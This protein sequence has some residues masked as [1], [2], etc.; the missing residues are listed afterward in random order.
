MPWAVIS[1]LGWCISTLA[2]C[3]C[4]SAPLVFLNRSFDFNYIESVAVFP[5]ENLSQSQGA[6]Q[7]ATLMFVTEMLSLGSFDVV[8]MGE[9]SKAL[10]ELNQAR[11]GG[12][13]TPGTL[14]VQQIIQLGKRLKVQG[15]IFGTVG[16][17]VVLRSGGYSAPTITMDLRMVETETGTTVWAASHTESGS[18]WLSTLF[19]VSSKSTS[20]TMRECIHNI[21]KTLIK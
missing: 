7:Q 4:G 13:P 21:L 10:T 1:V 8:E 20:E 9:T 6:G 18:N 19:G 12:A 16:E 15:L 2:L 14:D 5:F 3:G 17:S 11:S